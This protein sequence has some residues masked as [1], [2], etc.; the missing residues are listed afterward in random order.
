MGAGV[1]G[2]SFVIHDKPLS[3]PPELMLIKLLLGVG[4]L[5]RFRAMD[6]RKIYNMTERGAGLERSPITNGQ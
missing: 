6:N 3:T 2:A 4:G 1:R 5:D